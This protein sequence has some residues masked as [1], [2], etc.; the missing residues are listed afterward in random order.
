MTGTIVNTLAIIA[1]AMIGVIAKKAIP[2]RMGDLVMSAIPIVVM[3]LGV[4]FGIASSNILI[5]IVSLVVGG[6]IGEWIDIDRRLDDFG[7][8]IQSRMKGGDSNFSA[9]FVSTTLIYCVGSMAILGSIESGINGNH[10]ILYTKSL[11][12][13]ISAIFFAS[14]LG[15]GVIFSGISVFIYQGILTVLA[16]YIGPYL[17]PEVV[18]EMSASGGILLIALSFTILGIKKIKVANLLPA[19]FLPVILMLFMK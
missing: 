19:I 6:I 12:D 5:V 17:S 15:A 2:Q 4:Q 18:T 10:T 14:T 7:V 8:R 16:G 11:M 13:G 1:G 3:V 9:A